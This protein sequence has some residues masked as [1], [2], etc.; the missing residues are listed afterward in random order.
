M[1]TEQILAT[2]QNPQMSNALE[3]KTENRTSN[4]QSDLEGRLRIRNIVREKSGQ[5]SVLVIIWMALLLRFH[6]FFF[7]DSLLRELCTFQ[8]ADGNLKPTYRWYQLDVVEF[9]TFIATPLLIGDSV[10]QLLSKD[11]ARP[12][13]CANFARNMFQEILGMKGFN[14]A[15]EKRQ[16]CIQI[17]CSQ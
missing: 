14:N 5:T 7:R 1:I 11:D 2:N 16:T 4:Q 17:H 10:H 8:N 6:Y 12:I 13:F 9:N 15:G 3:N